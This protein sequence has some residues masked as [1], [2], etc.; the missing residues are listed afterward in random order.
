MVSPI[1][2]FPS[3]LGE[4][5]GVIKDGKLVYQNA[6]G[7]VNSYKQDGTRI[8]NGTKVTNTNNWIQG[9]ITLKAIWKEVITYK[10]TPKTGE[11]VSLGLK[12]DAIYN[13]TTDGT[14]IY[15]Q[16]YSDSTSS[17]NSSL[18]SCVLL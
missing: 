5:W 1:L 2:L 18:F 13:L 14:T 8:N 4:G 7:L 3:A 11:I 6:W 16:M 15:G 10:V 9:D 12:A 17:R